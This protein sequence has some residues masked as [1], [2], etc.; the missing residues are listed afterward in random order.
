MAVDPPQVW[1][2]TVDGR[3]HRVEA[4]GSVS[5]RVEW[6]VDGEKVAEK[7]AMEDRLRLEHGEDGEHGRLLVVFSGLGRPRRATVFGPGEDAQAMTGLGGTDLAPEVGSPAAAYEEKVLAH[8][9]RYAAVQTLGGVAKVV[10]PIVLALLAARIAINVPWPDV[11]LPSI[12]FPDLPSIP[13]PSIPWPDLPRPN[14]PDVSLPDWV[15]WLLDKVKYVW[16]VVLAFV[17]ARGEVNRRRKQ[18][19]LRAEQAAARD[20]HRSTDPDDP[21]ADGR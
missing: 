10:V 16:P 15:R 5:H 14:L 1:E 3:S 9:R 18:Q 7:K 2:Q 4:S 12:P 13:W 19:E 20:G 6:W 21:D 8:P 17:L 11:D